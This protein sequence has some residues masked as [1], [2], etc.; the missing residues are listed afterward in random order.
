MAI[1]VTQHFHLG[2]AN[3]GNFHV[4]TQ[5]P[6]ATKATTNI[7]L[8]VKEA[9]KAGKK[10]SSSWTKMIL[11]AVW[12]LIFALGLGLAIAGGA[13]ANTVMGEIGSLIV[14]AMAG[15]GIKVF[16][17]AFES[18]MEEEQGETNVSTS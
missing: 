13:T 7:T 12:V 18:T 15:R 2:G 9:V 3:I 5:S 1:T 10:G 14:T 4:P 16:E 17:K 11:I 6:A 8:Q